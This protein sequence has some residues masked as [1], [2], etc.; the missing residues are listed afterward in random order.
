MNIQDEINKA[1]PIYGNTV[2]LEVS[3][4]V[5]RGIATPREISTWVKDHESLAWLEGASEPVIKNVWRGKLHTLVRRKDRFGNYRHYSYL[6][7]ARGLSNV[8][9][10]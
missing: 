10:S 3:D 6:F 1:E 8:P 9:R 4:L 5:M 2:R 7:V